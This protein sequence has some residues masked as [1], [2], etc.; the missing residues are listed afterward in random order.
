[1]EIEIIRSR[2]AESMSHK[3]RLAR[4]SDYFGEKANLNFAASQR[5][6]D[7]QS[8]RHYAAF[9]ESDTL[10]AMAEDLMMM[11]SLFTT[12]DTLTRLL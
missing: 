9:I 6:L 11:L 4:Y 8:A 1:M 7:P 5:A 2:L 10:T 12:I 3:G